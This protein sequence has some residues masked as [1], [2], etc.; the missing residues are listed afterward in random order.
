MSGYVYLIGTSIFH[1]YKIGKSK[2]PEI[3]IGDLG[4]LLPFK[5]KVYGVWKAD[6]HTM[7][8][9]T[10]HDI[11]SKYRINGEWFEFKNSTIKEIFEKLPES[12]CIFSA[13]K[14]KTKTLSN[15]SNIDED[16]SRGRKVT[17][18]NRQ[19]KQKHDLTKEECEKRRLTSIQQQQMNK[20]L[21]SA[22]LS[23]FDYK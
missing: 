15:F 2:T 4:I 6:N 14:D 17:S 22:Q 3:R 21:R 12:S 19:R 1:W 9:S 23:L 11:Y 8:E 16:T 5:I 20:I 10:L 13:K 18:V 7:L